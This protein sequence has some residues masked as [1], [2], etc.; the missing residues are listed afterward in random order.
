MNASCVLL[1]FFRVEAEG[2]KLETKTKRFWLN[3]SDIELK[4][5]TKSWGATTAV[6]DVSF[7]VKSG[8]FSILL[9]PSGCGKS[10]T[11]RMIAGLEEVTGGHLWI[12]GKDMT[13]SFPAERELSMVFQSYALFPHLNVA[14][15]IAFGL[16]VRKVSSAEQASR[17]TRVANIVGLSELM[18]RKPGQL[19]GRQ[20][21]RVALAR[22]IIAENKICL[23]DDNMLSHKKVYQYTNTVFKDYVKDTL[24]N[25][26]IPACFW[27]EKVRYECATQNA[28]HTKN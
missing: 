7:T 27:V 2:C 12:A 17:L 19:S 15:N 9:G 20:R 5:I 16:K 14:D 23:M 28:A 3:M 25:S 21:Q 8:S 24:F 26:A 4:N 13:D 6:D 22:A 10:T 11:L 1:V 18:D